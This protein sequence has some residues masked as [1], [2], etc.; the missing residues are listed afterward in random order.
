MWCT[1]HDNVEEVPKIQENLVGK[2]T[3]KFQYKESF[4]MKDDNDNDNPQDINDKVIK[5]SK[6]FGVH[7]VYDQE[8][9]STIVMKMQVNNTDLRVIKILLAI[10]VISVFTAMLTGCHHINDEYPLDL[11]DVVETGY[12]NTVDGDSMYWAIYEEWDNDCTRNLLYMDKE[13]FDALESAVEEY[14]KAGL[15][16]R[17][18]LNKKHEFTL[19]RDS[20]GLHLCSIR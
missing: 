20:E 15:N 12:G 6:R 7:S 4:I 16:E 10:I 18:S 8:S 1:N 11:A 9:Q 5:E 13:T 3:K 2:S 19:L 17:D 14:N